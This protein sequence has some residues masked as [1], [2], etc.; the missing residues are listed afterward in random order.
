MSP[1]EV[2]ALPIFDRRQTIE[3]LRQEEAGAPISLRDF[4]AR[5]TS[6]W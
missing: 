1:E 6:C 2:A 3:G 5:R 4:A